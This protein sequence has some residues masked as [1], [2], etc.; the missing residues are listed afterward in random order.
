[1]DNRT[2]QIK[3][4]LSKSKVNTKNIIDALLANRGL[5]NKREK[6]KF[7]NPTDPQD[8][9]LSEIGLKKTQ[10]E[11]SI[12]RIKNA[13]KKS[14]LVIIYGDYD[15]DGV[16]ATAVLWETLN[17]LGA[18]VQPYI[19]DRFSEGYGLNPETLK[20][21]KSEN[22]NLSLIITVDN[23][24]V[25]DKAVDQANELG[26]D[27]II[28]DHHEP[29]DN[30]PKA[31]SIVHTTKTSGS[32]VAW[33]FAR[34]ILKNIKHA[35]KNFFK[36]SLELVA[37]G[38]VADQL[39]LLGINRSLVTSGIKQLHDTKRPGLVNLIS[40]AGIDQT[41]IGMYEIGFVIA[42]R[43]NSAGRLA[44]AIDSLRLVCTPNNIRALKLANQIDKTNT[45]RQKIVEEVVTLARTTVGEVVEKSIIVIANEGYHEGVI[46]LA[47]SRLV[48][49]FYRPSI[50]IS[51]G[52]KVSKASARSISGFSII[53]AIRAHQDLILEGGG[54]TM[55]AGFSIKTSKINEFTELIEQYSQKNIT[56]QMLQK[57]LTIDLELPF[58]ALNF[59]LAEKLQEF[60]PTGI[61]NPSAI[62]CT[63]NAKVV[64]AKALGKEGKH[65]KLVLSDGTNTVE[66]IAFGYGADLNSLIN[67]TI[68]VAFNLEIN[69][70]NGSRSL[71]LKVRDIILVDGKSKV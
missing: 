24:I 35:S 6:Q 60:E 40:A 50:V 25:A 69:S 34:E 48:E 20:R 64:N 12:S 23:G 68:N 62:F 30:L 52:E 39:P 8:I 56:Q 36:T 41:K 27:V 70:W 49:V 42:P 16:C 53:D 55:A 65:L 38:T 19:P 46:G 28:T 54:H 31:Y 1:M 5:E 7:F 61:G 17:T 63:K 9:T 58:S 67:Q 33:F 2:W 29:S 66:A 57:K 26:I 15:A 13:I 32:G 45:D 10:L 21:L 71:Q 44:H 3:N 59:D 37:I 43:I 51:K 11:R 22:S 47:A 14:E 18:N 4:K